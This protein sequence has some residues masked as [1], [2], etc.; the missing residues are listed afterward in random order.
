LQYKHSVD[1]LVLI[2]APL[3]SALVFLGII[4]A[5]VCFFMRRKKMAAK[6]RRDN[7]ENYYL[8]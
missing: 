2:L 4:V 1:S 5:L 8:N 6:R 7:N 3:F